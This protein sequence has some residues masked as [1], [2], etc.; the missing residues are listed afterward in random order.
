MATTERTGLG[1]LITRM[2][3]IGVGAVVMT[4]DAVQKAVDDMVNRGEVSREEGRKLVD[5]M[6]EKGEQQ[7]THLQDMVDRAV[8]RVMTR[9]DLAKRSELNHLQTRVNQLEARL[10]RLEMEEPGM[11]PPVEEEGL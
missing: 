1:D 11:A 9:M 7:R 4:K 6:V 8:E 5:E 3:D 10:A 2:V